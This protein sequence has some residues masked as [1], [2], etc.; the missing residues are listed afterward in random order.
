MD[1]PYLLTF[2]KLN[3][4]L[5]PMIMLIGQDKPNGKRDY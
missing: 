2:C 5:K 3:K 1:S 4:A